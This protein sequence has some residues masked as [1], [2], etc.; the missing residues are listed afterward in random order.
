MDTVLRF[1]VYPEMWKRLALRSFGKVVNT[2]NNMAAF[3]ADARTLLDGLI[4]EDDN[5]LVE[6][7][8]QYMVEEMDLREQDRLSRKRLDLNALSDERFVAAVA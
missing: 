7:F 5:D 3:A 2:N 1:N 6:L 8:M 4:L